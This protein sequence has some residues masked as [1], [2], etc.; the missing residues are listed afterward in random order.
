MLKRILI[1]EKKEIH[2]PAQRKNFFKTTCKSKGKVCKV[3]IG[4][5]SIDNLVST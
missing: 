5:G 2:E 3:V 4:S 1:K